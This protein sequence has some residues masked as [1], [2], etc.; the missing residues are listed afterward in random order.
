MHGAGDG[1]IDNRLKFKQNLHL[2]G[3]GGTGLVFRGQVVFAVCASLQ[4][5]SPFG[6]LTG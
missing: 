2:K 6:T 1:M 4:F 5:E 3:T